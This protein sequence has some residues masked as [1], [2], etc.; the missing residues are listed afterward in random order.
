MI[1]ATP[2]RPFGRRPAPPSVVRRRP[3][4]WPLGA[5]PGT[6][7]LFGDAAD[8]AAMRIRAPGGSVGT[9]STVGAPEGEPVSRA[10]PASPPSPIRVRAARCTRAGR[11]AGQSMTPMSGAPRFRPASSMP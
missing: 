11:E 5:E 6:L 8:A 9:R 3:A 10:V 7:T 2:A 1:P 4:G